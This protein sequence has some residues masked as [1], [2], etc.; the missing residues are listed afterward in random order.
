[1][2]KIVSV[3]KARAMSRF[4]IAHNYIF[5]RNDKLI[6]FT[7]MSNIQEKTNKEYPMY[8]VNTSVSKTD[9]YNGNEIQFIKRSAF[10]NGYELCQK[11]YEEKLRWI[12]VEEELPEIGQ[13]VLLKNEFYE[14]VGFL[15]KNKKDFR[16]LTVE[17]SD[18]NEKISGVTHWRFL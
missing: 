12:P 6:K 11:E 14:Y 10:Q 4:S 3:C 7:N 2:R 13:R 1:M 8:D 15:S 9:E 5:F 16:A 17:I 18:S